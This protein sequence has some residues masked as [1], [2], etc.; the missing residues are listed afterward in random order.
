[1][2]D[3]PP[4]RV[5]YSSIPKSPTQ[6]VSY[7]LEDDSSSTT[8]R[9]KRRS[10]DINRPQAVPSKRSRQQLAQ[11]NSVLEEQLGF[12][13]FSS[14]DAGVSGDY[15]LRLSEA[16][17]ITAEEEYTSFVA[18]VLA[19]ECMICQVSQRLFMVNGWKSGEATVSYSHH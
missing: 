14:A 10:V 13:E 1:M 11:T 16:L 6:K 2:D 9:R 19:E 7:L 3:S 15:P 4:K 17:R 18:S 8:P 12:S 5:S